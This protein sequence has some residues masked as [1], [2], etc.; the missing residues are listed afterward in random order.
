MHNKTKKE[1][2]CT[3]KCETQTLKD[4][5]NAL[6]LE[7]L[8]T[9]CLTLDCYNDAYSAPDPGLEWR[10]TAISLACSKTQEKH[11][12]RSIQ[13]PTLSSKATQSHGAVP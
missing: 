6:K 13:R 3:L 7:V 9:T 5:L 8:M 10:A 12:Y 4:P 2:N 11:V 1:R